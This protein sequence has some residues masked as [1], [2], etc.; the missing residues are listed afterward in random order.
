MRKAMAEQVTGPRALS[1]AALEEL[2]REETAALC[3][4]GEGGGGRWRDRAFREL[5][6]SSLAGVQL[7]LRIAARTGIALPHSLLY[8][9]PTP[10]ELIG[11]L[12]RLMA[13]EPAPAPT[14][15]PTAALDEPI[16]IVAMAC[17]YPGGVRSPDDLWRL[18][19]DGV[20]ASGDFPADR[21]WDLADLYDPDP[22][23]I[24]SSDRKSV[25]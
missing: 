9:F 18:V 22:D 1:P 10:G 7:R 2:V 21:G 17:R 12:A 24:G 19:R 20:D 13:A 5:G 8:D 11:E 4:D 6:L 15:R 3:G 14:P 25:V 16:A 23:R